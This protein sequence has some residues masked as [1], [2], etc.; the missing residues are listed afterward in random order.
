MRARWAQLGW[1]LLALLAAGL[2]GLLPQ[3]LPSVR[4]LLMAPFRKLQLNSPRERRL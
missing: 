4:W 3:G 1:L 2:F